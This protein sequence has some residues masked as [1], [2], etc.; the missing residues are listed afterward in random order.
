[1]FQYP[2]SRLALVTL[3]QYPSNA[4]Q[5]WLDNYTIFVIPSS[6]DPQTGSTSATATKPLAGG[7]AA[8]GRTE[9]E[10]IVPL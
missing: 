5:L 4:L 1:M 9:G 3:Y 7:V 2:C 8:A 6:P 10:E